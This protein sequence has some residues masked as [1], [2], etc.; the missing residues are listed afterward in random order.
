MKKS[1]FAIYESIVSSPEETYDPP[2]N[3]DQMKD[4]LDPE[5]FAK[6][7]N[8]PVHR[9]RAETGIELIHREPSLEEFDRICRNW[10]LMTPEQKKLSDEKSKELFTYDNETRIPFLRKEYDFKVG[11]KVRVKKGIRCIQSG[12]TGTITEITGP[13]KYDWLNFTVKMDEPRLG[14]VQF[15]S[16]CIDKI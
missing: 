13:N 6:L 9:W 11:N 3:L 8:D 1:V 16:G 15:Q 12:H 7:E 5:T 10:E 2:M 4:N 14:A